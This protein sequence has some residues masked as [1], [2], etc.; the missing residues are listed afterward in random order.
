MEKLCYKIPANLSISYLMIDSEQLQFY[1]ANSRMTT[2]IVL[3]D[4]IIAL[5]TEEI[6]WNHIQCSIKT[7]ERGQKRDENRKKNLLCNIKE[8][9]TNMVDS[10]PMI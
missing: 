6:K 10:I 1:T 8:T 2:K 9:A 7:R 5:L 4:N 3:K